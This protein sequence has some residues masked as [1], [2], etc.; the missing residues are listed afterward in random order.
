MSAIRNVHAREIIDSRGNPTVEV[1]VTT[2]KGTFTAAVPSGASTGIYEALEMR[3]GDTARYLGKGVQKACEN[4][5]TI[6]K[7][8]I[9]G[10][11]V[12]Q[13]TELDNFMVQ[14]LD[15]T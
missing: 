13:Q 10:R 3:D 4:V 7:D 9:V 1:D 5:N 14:E 6:I 11:D 15:A 2:D 12:T 8:A